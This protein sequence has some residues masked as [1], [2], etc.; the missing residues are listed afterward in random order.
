MSALN[1]SHVEDVLDNLY[2]TFVTIATGV[3]LAVLTVI[4]NS[5]KEHFQNIKHLD[6]KKEL[7]NL[8]KQQLESSISWQSSMSA[9]TSEGT[10]ERNTDTK[11][12][13]ASEPSAAA[14]E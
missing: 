11:K 13:G 1:A 5:I 6:L 2:T 12:N 8:K 9:R 10:P 14:S 3:L 7:N 4:G